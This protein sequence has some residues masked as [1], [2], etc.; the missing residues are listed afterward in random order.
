MDHVVSHKYCILCFWVGCLSSRH[1]PLT[2]SRGR[3]CIDISHLPCSDSRLVF[4]QLCPIIKS[5]SI[6]YHVPYIYT[7]Q[8]ARLRSSRNRFAIAQDQH[9]Q[10]S[11]HDIYKIEALTIYLVSSSTIINITLVFISAKSTCDIPTKPQ[12][13]HS[14]HLLSILTV[15]VTPA[16]LNRTRVVFSS[17]G[18][19]AR[20]LHLV[21]SRKQYITI[22][23]SP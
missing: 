5:F 4:G 9:R 12:T 6:I 22:N 11:F 15:I 1:V 16:P 14:N 10:W 17:H 19:T 3:M 13:P 21:E 23:T 7:L 18:I 2:S 8:S 20:S